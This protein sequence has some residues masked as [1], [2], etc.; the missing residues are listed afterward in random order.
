VA[1]ASKLGETGSHVGDGVNG[2]GKTDIDIPNVPHDH[3]GGDHPNVGDHGPADA[4]DPRDPMHTG[5]GHDGTGHDG[6][7]HNPPATHGNPADH[8]PP[9]DPS[10]PKTD[11]R[12]KAEVSTI[13]RQIQP[14]L[15][16]AADDSW[17]RALARANAEG[18]KPTAQRLGSY[19]HTAMK[20]WVERHETEFAAKHPGYRMLPEQSFDAAGDPIAQGAKDSIRPDI[21]I[22]RET[23]GGNYE[24][25]QAYDLKTGNAHI[26][27]AWESKVQNRLHPVAPTET[28]R[29]GATPVGAGAGAR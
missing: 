4:P 7:G 26:T 22:E 25:V 18:V 2:L 8:T 21:V 5:T 17:K 11:P 29:P 13:R 10:V 3:V 24:V 23:P 27:H 28:L 6:T 14:D 20:E 15:Q 19:A 9:T 16:S 12:V 1:G